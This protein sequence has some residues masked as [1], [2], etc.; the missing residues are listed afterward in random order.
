MLLRRFRTSEVS[1]GQALVEFAIVLPL[2]A[3]LL[4]MAIDFGRV[5][6]GWVSVTNASR[7]AAN[8]AAMYPE[9]WE[10]GDTDRLDTY[11][12][13]VSSSVSGCTLSGPVPAPTFTDTDGDG[14]AYGVGDEAR[15][16]LRCDF[17]LLTPLAGSIVGQPLEI[18][19]TSAFPIRI[20]QIGLPS[21]TGGNPP[22][23]G[24]RV[25]N[26][27]NM[28]VEQAEQ[29]WSDAGFTGAFTASP[30]EDDHIVQT[31]TLSPAAAVN[32]C[33]DPSSSV[34]VTATPP[35]PCP[36]GQLQVP[37][38]VGQLLPTARTLWADAGFTGSFSPSAGHND[39][40]VLSQTTSPTNVTPGGCL[41]E[42]G[43]VSTTWGDP[44]VPN[45]D[46]PNLVGLSA[47]AAQTDWSDAGFFDPLSVNGNGAFV[48]R[49]DPQFPG[50]V[51]CDI[52]GRVWMRN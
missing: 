40:V 22:C 50:T 16:A 2:L 24:I 19:G 52:R 9:A 41:A 38:M 11:Q 13:I 21:G 30:N 15:V 20:G 47:A 18:G 17:T 45:C 36:S 12:S 44:P 10:D 14:D 29:F 49:Q 23:S 8:Y 32:E 25:P 48:D 4:V 42:D 31:Q 7:V 37:N 35:P 5:F 28:T 39:K 3:L 6:F 33:V 46:V 1:R 27:V 51:P 26:L 34:F 43:S